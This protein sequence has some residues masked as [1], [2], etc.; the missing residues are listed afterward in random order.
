MRQRTLIAAWPSAAVDDLRVDQMA[1]AY[2]C[3]DIYKR[4]LAQAG[5]RAFLVAGVDDHHSE[6]EASAYR[7]RSDPDALLGQAREAIEASWRAYSIE[8]DHRGERDAGYAPHVHAFFRKLLRAG[9]IEVRSMP[10][11]YEIQHGTYPIDAWVHGSCPTCLDWTSGGFCEACGTPNSSVELLGLDPHRY[12]LRTEPRLVFE[13]ERFR[14]EIEAS[15]ALPRALRGLLEQPLAPFVLSTKSRRGVSAAFAD[16]PDQ[17][18]HS[19]GEL[20][21]GQLYFAQQAAGSV[22]AADEYVYFASFSAA[23]AVSFLHV[24]LA[25]AARRCELDWPAPSALLV[26]TRQRTHPGA[27]ESSILA[28]EL[29]DV[30]NSDVVRAYLAM[31]GPHA[32]EACYSS[33]AFDASLGPIAT[34]IE[35]LVALWNEQRSHPEAARSCAPPRDVMHCMSV[36]TAAV[37]WNAAELARRALRVLA[38]FAHKAAKARSGLT[39]YIPSVLAMALEPL[40]PNYTDELRERFP[41]AA[42]SWDELTLCPLDKELPRFS[43]K[44]ESAIILNEELPERAVNALAA[45]MQVPLSML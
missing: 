27:S 16:L 45:T 1:G 39:R 33:A 20:Y 13:L 14:A 31:T 22:S 37:D 7:Q 38:Y 42:D 44:A 2:L 28:R 19:A 12:A 30:F 11:L 10:V 34:V 43:L 4:T 25:A 26:S 9:L 6:V 17:T 29:T 32:H 18:L 8:A 15:P 40:C 24:A 5:A 36:Q 41:T 35:R 3:S 23:Y 21:A